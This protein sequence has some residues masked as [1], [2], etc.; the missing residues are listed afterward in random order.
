MAQ[1]EDRPKFLK[2]CGRVIYRLSDIEAYEESCL[3]L[4]RRMHVQSAASTIA[5]VGRPAD[6]ADT[7]PVLSKSMASSS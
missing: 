2:F 1:R 7:A 4:V 3:R 6:N 5:D